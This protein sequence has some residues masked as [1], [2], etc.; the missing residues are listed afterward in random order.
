MTP[1]RL[2]SSLLVRKGQAQ[3]IGDLDG[4]CCGLVQPLPAGGALTRSAAP[5]APMVE[6]LVPARVPMPATAGSGRSGQ[7]DPVNLTVRIDRTMH[8]RLRVLAAREQR[9]NQDI[10]RCALDAYLN[11]FA[12]GCTCVGGPKPKT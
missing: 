1:A 12:A 6:I 9:T 5:R 4:P 7:D 11:A 3:P 2:T 10:V 8:T